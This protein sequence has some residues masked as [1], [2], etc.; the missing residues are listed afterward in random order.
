MHAI[1]ICFYTIYNMFIL[2]LIF[3]SI[4]T[5]FYL[6]ANPYQYYERMRPGHCQMICASFSPGGTFLAAGSAD[7]HV[8]IYMMQEDEGPKR[9]HEIGIHTGRLTI[10]ILC[11]IC[12]TY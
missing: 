12:P 9:I 10:H 7:H 6:R 4:L 11:F 2:E 5:F 8:R 1:A 3:I